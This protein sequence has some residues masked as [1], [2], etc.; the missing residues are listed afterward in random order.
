MLI[1]FIVFTIGLDIIV[2]KL[3]NKDNELW[4]KKVIQYSKYFYKV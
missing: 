3:Y 2:I 1:K 4:Q